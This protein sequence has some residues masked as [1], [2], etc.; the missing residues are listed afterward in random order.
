MTNKEI[1]KTYAV[2]GDN[3]GPGGDSVIVIDALKAMD[4][5]RE[6]GAIRFGVWLVDDINPFVYH[7]DGRYLQA[8]GNSTSWTMEELY[9]L[10]KKQN[11]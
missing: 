1:L 4:A 9:A 11:P 3:P 2:G 6:D 10:Y 5:A 8:C 7:K